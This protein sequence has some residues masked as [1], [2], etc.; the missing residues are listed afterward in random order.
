[1]RLRAVVIGATGAVGSALVAELLASPKWDKVEILTRRHTN[2]FNNLPGAIK[3]TQY[4]INMDNLEAEA[5]QYINNCDV[6]F[7]TLG[8][9]E[10]TKVSKETLWRV[11]VDYPSKFA[12]A[13]Q[14]SGVQHINLLTS[15]YFERLIRFSYF[16]RVKNTVENNFSNLNFMRCSFFRPSLLVTKNIR[17]GFKDY[18]NQLVFPFIS[19]L[20]PSIFHEVKV[21]DLAKAMRL[22]AE[23]NLENSNSVEIIHY[24]E[25]KQLLANNQN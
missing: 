5:L 10:P 4:T 13:C 2:Q 6:A 3:L 7:C 14:L 12:K 16:F 9:G 22:N 17:Y 20:L 25:I 21:E 11:E 18:F 19:V 23:K 24:P 15:V 1:M 8:I